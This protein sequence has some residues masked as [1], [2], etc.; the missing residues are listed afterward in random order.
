MIDTPPL[1]QPGQGGEKLKVKIH[2]L[3]KIMQSMKLL[4]FT[5]CFKV[6]IVG[7]KFAKTENIE[8]SNKAA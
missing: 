7:N 1:A 6:L 3:A 5:S 8:K 4:T 2:I